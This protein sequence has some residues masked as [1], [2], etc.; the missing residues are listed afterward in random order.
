MHI[1]MHGIY[2]VNTAAKESQNICLFVAV[3]DM[4]TSISIIPA[5]YTAMCKHVVWTH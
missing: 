1:Y 4:M 5:K 2:L 3:N